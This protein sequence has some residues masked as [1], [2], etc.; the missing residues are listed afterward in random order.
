[1]KKSFLI[2]TAA[3]IVSFTA[4]QALAQTQSTTDSNA[5]TGTTTTTATTPTTAPAGASDV[6]GALNSNADYTTASL[7]VK[8]AQ[9][10]ATLKT[11]GPYTIFA[12]NNAAFSKLPQGQ[13]DSLM[14]DPVKLATLLKGHVVSGK[15]GKADIIKAL[16]AGKGK[17]A[18]TT[19]DGQPLTLSISS[20]KTLQLTNAAGNSSEVTL[21]DLVGANGVVNGITTVLAPTKQ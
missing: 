12:P 17:A 1:M 18:L 5:T 6:V 16:N 14:K 19:L 20:A 7:A 4:N 11:G 15:Y 8:S 13:L 2:V 3:A 9:L 21:Y 10:E